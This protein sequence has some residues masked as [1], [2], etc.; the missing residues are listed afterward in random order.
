R[1]AAPAPVAI[2]E[3]SKLPMGSHGLKELLA[4]LGIEVNVTTVAEGWDRQ[5]ATRQDAYDWLIQLSRHP[6]LVDLKKFRENVDS[7]L[8]ENEEGFYF[9][10]PTSSDITW[11]KTR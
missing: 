9:F 7:F 10:L 6:E 2:D 4:P 11:F 8:T 1:P 5:F 3:H